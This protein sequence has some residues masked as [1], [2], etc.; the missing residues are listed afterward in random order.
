VKQRRQ[1]VQ[2]A[3]I[4]GVRPAGR[5]F[6]VGRHTVFERI[7]VVRGA[8]GLLNGTG[9]PSAAVNLVRKHADSKTASGTVSGNLASWR[10]RTGT[11]DVSTPI[12]RSG[13]VRARGV[14]SFS[15]QNAFIDIETTQSSAL[16]GVLD[17]DL[18][19]EHALIR[20]CLPCTRRA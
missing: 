9:D 18:S 11:V 17:A 6:G 13:S 10:Q 4:H 19:P 15:K 14:A 8:T 3:E 16:C 20:R 12:N 2:Y 7:E 1:V 5:H